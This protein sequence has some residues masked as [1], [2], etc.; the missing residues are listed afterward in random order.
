VGL[1][2]SHSD[3]LQDQDHAVNGDVSSL[4]LTVDNTSR[5]GAWIQYQL[6]P[7]PGI[8]EFR[9]RWDNR[10]SARREPMDDDPAQRRS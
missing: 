7:Q 5:A 9:R 8:G 3:R 10:P 2:P 1:H 4:Q 6:E